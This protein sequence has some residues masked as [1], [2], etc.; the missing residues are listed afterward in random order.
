LDGFEAGFNEWVI[1]NGEGEAGDDYMTE[2]FA[3]NVD[4]HPE[5]IE[6][7]ENAGGMFS[8]R[9][10]HVSGGEPASLNEKAVAFGF[11][12]VPEFVGDV[13]HKAGVGE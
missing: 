13:A 9:F 8:K 5:S 10:E 1:G 4:A 12:F 6:P 7:E 3:L 2:G 11:K